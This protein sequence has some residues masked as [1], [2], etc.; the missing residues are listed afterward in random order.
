MIVS[1]PFLVKVHEL[2]AYAMFDYWRFTPRGL[3]LL[4]EGGRPGGR[5]GGRVG[6][7]P[8]RGRKPQ[9]L[10]GLPPLAFARQRARPGGPGLGLRQEPAV[11]LRFPIARSLSQWPQSDDLPVAEDAR[12]TTPPC[13]TRG[14][15]SA[16]VQRRTRRLTRSRSCSSGSTHSA[17]RTGRLAIRRSS[18][19]CSGFATEP[20]SSSR[21]GPRPTSTTR[22]LT[23]TGCPNG[24]GLPEVSPDELT[25]GLLRAAILR[26]GCLL[27]RGLVD[28]GQ[29]TRL[30]DGIDRAF[31]AREQRWV[32]WVGRQRRTTRCSSRLPSSTWEASE[33]GSPTMRGASGAPTPPG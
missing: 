7:P 15:G 4:L 2:P 10:V 5:R 14:R 33:G 25:P 20:V 22:L 32:G 3:R 21:T 11:M 31:E 6:Q 30:V 17:A 29:A 12:E 24:S 19:A 8:V 13:R 27:V 16:S 23:S 26:S 18:V 1:T 9:P 28:P